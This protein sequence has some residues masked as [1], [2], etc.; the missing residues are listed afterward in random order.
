MK[1]IDD[2]V[3]R[4]VDQW[5]PERPDLDLGAMATVARISQLARLFDGV[6]DD[7]A[8]SYGLQQAEGDVLFTLRRAGTPYRL[9]PAAIS[10][11]LLVSSGTLTSRLDRLEDKGLIERVP[12]PPDRRSVEVQLTGQARRV[13]DEAVTVHVH[14]EQRMLAPLSE[15]EMESLNRIT[16][17]LI[18]HIASGAWR[19]SD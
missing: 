11:S 17:K 18:G 3:Q 9:S 8:A 15:R 4:L 16:S 7:L 6:I 2:Q 5:G 19:E 13:V 12:H 1:R 14:N 10:E